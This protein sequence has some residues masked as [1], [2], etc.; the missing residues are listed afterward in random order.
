LSGSQ[1]GL[2]TEL[3][4]SRITGFETAMTETIQITNTFRLFRIGL[5]PFN[6]FPI[7]IVFQPG[8][9]YGPGR[10]TGRTHKGDD[11]FRSS[12]G[13]HTFKVGMGIAF[14]GD[15]KRGSDLDAAGSNRKKFC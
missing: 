4:G 9:Q 12:F 8:S 13:Q 5:G 15:G 3:S 14:F 10:K 2:N 1:S 6:L 11:I 7:Q